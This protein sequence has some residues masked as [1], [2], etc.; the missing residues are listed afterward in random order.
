MQR[1]SGIV[2]DGGPFQ[3]DPS[4]MPASMAADS[5]KVLNVLPACRCELAR[6]VEL[7]A[8]VARRDHRHRADRAPRRGRFAIDR[9]GRL[10]GL[11]EPVVDRAGR[12]ALQV[13]VERRW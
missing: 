13:R 12:Q 11:P 1:G 2:S 9:G 4:G 10:A 7:R 3:T 8:L 5:A 6:E